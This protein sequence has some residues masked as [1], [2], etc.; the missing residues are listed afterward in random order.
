MNSFERDQFLGLASTAP[1][2]G[3]GFNGELP[4]WL[5]S[6]QSQLTTSLLTAVITD[7]DTLIGRVISSMRPSVLA[8]KAISLA[9]FPPSSSSLFYCPP[10]TLR[11]AHSSRN[12]GWRPGRKNKQ[13]IQ[14]VEDIDEP[15][16]QAS[17]QNIIDYQLSTQGR[18]T[19]TSVANVRLGS[20]ADV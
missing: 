4:T 1:D 18:V 20:A 11:M 3:T 5:V 15:P 9:L 12:V 19:A 14:L 10:S 7:G 2:L 16:D 6:R 8:I 17:S 13:D